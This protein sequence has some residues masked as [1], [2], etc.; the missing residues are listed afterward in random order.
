[1]SVQL[2]L[3]GVI[4]IVTI[5]MVHSLVL[6]IMD[7]GSMLITRHVMVSG[8]FQYFGNWLYKEFAQLAVYVYLY[9]SFK[10]N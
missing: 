7:T 10:K 3:M 6:V 2:I 4:R 9:S 5:V 8:H 1:M